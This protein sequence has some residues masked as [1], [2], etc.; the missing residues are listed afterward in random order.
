[1]QLIGKLDSPFVRRVAV[2]LK[3]LGRPFEHLDWSVGR[4]QSRIRAINPLGRVPTLVLDSGEVLMESSAILDHLDQEAGPAHSLLPMS[5]SDRRRALRLLALAT[6]AAEKC[7]AQIHEQA[8]RP[9]E[10]RHAPWVERC[11]EQ[12]RG[13]LGELDRS[14]APARAPLWTLGERFSQADITSA[15][16]F[17]FIA[18]AVGIDRAR[19]PALTSL[20]ARCEEMPVFRETYMGFAAPRA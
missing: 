12:M 16:V 9:E 20:T 10:K 18:D 13:S 6:G 19:Y 8:F 4:D 5:G 15:I 7:V 1:M 2:S 17:T 11:V 14:V 3:L